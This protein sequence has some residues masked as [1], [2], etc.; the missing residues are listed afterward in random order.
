MLPSALPSLT[1]S[2]NRMTSKEG[3]TTR[4][5]T[6]EKTFWIDAALRLFLIIVLMMIETMMIRRSMRRPQ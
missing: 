5:E 4:L 1:L 3:R 2:N 6:L